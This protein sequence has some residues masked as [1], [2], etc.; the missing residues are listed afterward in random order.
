MGKPGMLQSMGSQRVTHDWVTEQQSSSHVSLLSQAPGTGLLPEVTIKHQLSGLL[1]RRGNLGPESP[2]D[3][4]GRASLEPELT[5][6]PALWTV[7]DNLPVLTLHGPALSGSAPLLRTPF[8]N[9]SFQ[10]IILFFP[11]PM[12]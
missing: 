6:A 9:P 1:F 8:L 3:H 7:P 11:F 5:P 2:R 12:F 4:G 10:C